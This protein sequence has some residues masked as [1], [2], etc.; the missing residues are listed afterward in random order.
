MLASS[1]VEPSSDSVRGVLRGDAAGTVGSMLA[2]A[3]TRSVPMKIAC[4][5]IVSVSVGACLAQSQPGCEGVYFLRSGAIR[6]W[7][8][9]PEPP[10]IAGPGGEWVAENMYVDEMRA[11]LRAME[12]EPFPCISNGEARHRRISPSLRRRQ[13]YTHTVRMVADEVFCWLP[14]MG[15]VRGVPWLRVLSPNTRCSK[16]ESRTAGC[17][18]LPK[19]ILR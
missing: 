2:S 12:G 7:Q 14:T 11:F 10:P 6:E 5:A 9:F 16:A 19:R 8:D 13:R 4:L 1:T 17:A 3:A 15:A 18:L